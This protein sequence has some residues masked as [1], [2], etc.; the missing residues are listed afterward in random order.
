MDLKEKLGMY[1]KT[2][3][4]E[5]LVNIDRLQKEVGTLCFCYHREAKLDL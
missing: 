3:L 2:G 4:Y 1:G 5:T